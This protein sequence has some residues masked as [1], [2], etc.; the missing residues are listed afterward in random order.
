M[1]EEGVLLKERGRGGGTDRQT[2]SA[3]ASQIWWHT[4]VITAQ[5]PEASLNSVSD[6]VSEGKRVQCTASLWACPVK[7]RCWFSLPS[8][9][10]VP[11]IHIQRTPHCVK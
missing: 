10:E 11:V 9:E 7:N 3:N 2:D 1:K 5:E 6:P 4:P 8:L